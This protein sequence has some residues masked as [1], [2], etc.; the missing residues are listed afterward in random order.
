MAG[1]K[2]RTLMPLLVMALI[3]SARADVFNMQS[4]Q[5][6]LLTVP[7]GNS[8]N[9]NDPNTGNGYGGVP[10]NYEIG[11]YD[12]T[13]GQYTA[14]L[15]AVAA[16]DT[17]DLYD[18]NMATNLNVAGIAQN[19]TSGN[20]TYSAIGSSNHPITYVSWGDAARFANW[21]AN[22]QPTGGENNGTTETG[23]YTLNGATT[24]TDLGTIARNPNATWVIPTENEWYKAAFYNQT[25][26]TYYQYPFSNNNDPISCAAEQHA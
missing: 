10:Y 9:A 12:V 22:G 24:D 23:S 6:S 25:T 18:R 19:G 13:V 14:F 17:Y 2:T 1:M 16:T 20:Y 3:A 11:K 15:N 5:T 26:N 4:G 8:G 21:L 7:V